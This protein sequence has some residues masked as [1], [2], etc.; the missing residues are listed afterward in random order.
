MTAKTEAICKHSNM[1][2]HDQQ[3][4]TQHPILRITNSSKTKIC[5][6]II[7]LER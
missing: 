4:N 1:I 6:K 3:S 2:I 7:F 5:L